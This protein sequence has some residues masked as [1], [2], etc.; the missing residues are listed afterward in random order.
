MQMSIWLFTWIHSGL[1]KCVCPYVFV[2]VREINVCSLCSPCCSAPTVPLG[3]ICLPVINSSGLT[4][5]RFMTLFGLTN[6]RTPLSL[7]LT[8]SR[9]QGIEKQYLSLD[10]EPTLAAWYDDCAVFCMSCLLASI[11]NSVVLIPIRFCSIRFCTVIVLEQFLNIFS[12]FLSILQC[13]NTS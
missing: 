7:S 10:A 8:I 3:P 6:Y 2:C 5:Q 12:I 4:M 9:E 13:Q 11:S 1:E